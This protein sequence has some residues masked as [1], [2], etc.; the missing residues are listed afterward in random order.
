[1]FQSLGHTQVRLT[2]LEFVKTDVLTEIENSGTTQY[3]FKM[4]TKRAYGIMAF[5]NITQFSNLQW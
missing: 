4:Y 1:M 3:I 2:E 5:S